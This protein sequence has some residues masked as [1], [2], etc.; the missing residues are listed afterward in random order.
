VEY[1]GEKESCLT[2]GFTAL[3][4]KAGL[5]PRDPNL[6]SKSFNHM[7]I[8]QNMQRSTSTTSLP[9]ALQLALLATQK[10]WVHLLIQKKEDSFF[11]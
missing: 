1:L 10:S 7:G 11:K 2:H 8:T 3:Q 4:S 6:L 5:K 9:R